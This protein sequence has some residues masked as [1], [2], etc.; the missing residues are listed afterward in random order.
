MPGQAL[1][2]RDHLDLC[3][4]L[5]FSASFKLSGLWIDLRHTAYQRYLIAVLT[6]LRQAPAQRVIFQPDMSSSRSRHAT[7]TP[8]SQP[9]VQTNYDFNDLPQQGPGTQLILQTESSI[10]PVMTPG[11]HPTLFEEQRAT[12]QPRLPVRPEAGGVNSGI[13]LPGSMLFA[14][15]PR[16]SC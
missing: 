12:A 14:F 3:I 5:C 15:P 13:I 10:Q 9:T 1:D 4:S 11:T 6:G 7:A 16:L 2:M 8:S